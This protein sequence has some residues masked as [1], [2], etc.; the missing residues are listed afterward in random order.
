MGEVEA[1]MEAAYNQSIMWLMRQP[2]VYKGV[3]NKPCPP[4]SISHNYLTD[5]LPFRWR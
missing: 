4:T 2:F 5:A 3:F 1:A